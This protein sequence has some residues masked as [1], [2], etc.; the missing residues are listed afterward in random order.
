RAAA[1]RRR[2]TMA[3]TQC[4]SR[5]LRCDREYPTCS[6]CLKSRTPTKCTY[7]DGFLWQ[8]PATV[9]ATAFASDR[10]STVSLP[11]NEQT[12]IQTSPNPGLGP[13]STRSETL[14]STGDPGP[15]SNPY[16]GPHHHHHGRGRGH[17]G[18]ER[19]FLETVLGAPKAAVNQEP[20]VNAGF[21]Q[22]PK[23]A[24]P[25]L[26]IPFGSQVDGKGINDE[27]S[28]SELS[29]TQQLD[30][31]PRIMMR[32][33]ETKTRFSGSGIYAN[34]IAQFPDIRSFAEEIRLSNPILS[35]VR[36]DLE[37]VKRGLWKVKPLNTPFPEPT[38][39]SLISLLP[40]RQVVDEL[41]GLYLTYI[42]STHR[43]F[44]I[45]TFL[46]EVDD[47]FSMV[48]DPNMVSTA[49]VV[50]LLLVI[51]CAWN[52]ADA[53]S[54]QE[55]S[56]VPLKCYTAVEW[57]LHAERWIENARIKRFEIS[58]LRLYILLVTALN[59]H[60]MKR[61]KAWVTTGSLVQNAMLSGY[62]RD[63]SKYAR[64][65]PFNKEMRRRIWT[66]IV[67][68]NLQVSFDR[69]MP[70]SVQ[71]SDFDTLPPLNIDDE[72]IDET[73]TEAPEARPLTDIT[74]CSF[75]VALTRSLPLR[76]KACQLMHS[77]HI[78]CRYEEIQRLDLELNRQ[79]SRIPIWGAS[80]ASDI[81][82]QHKVSLRK[83]TIE[84]KIAQALL[85]IHT[86]F[87]I[88]AR[89]E[90]L[91]AP[92][93]R[94]RLD[95][96]IMILSTQRQLHTT[97]LPL[98]LCTLGEWVLQAYISICQHLHTMDHHNSLP[99]HPSSS[100]FTMHTLPGL[101]D[102]FLSLVEAGLISL[103][104]RFLLVVKGAKDYFFLSTIIALVKAKLWP[105][106]ELVYKQ[107]V[108]E[109]VLSFAQ[110]LFSR[111]A[112]CEHL[113]TPGMGSFKNNQ[114]AAFL[115]TRGMAAVL[116]SDFDGILLQPD[117]AITVRLLPFRRTVNPRAFLT[118][119]QPP[120]EFDPFLD[121]FDWEDL[122]GIAFGN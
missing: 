3:C 30:L 13:T 97:S 102:P 89:R 45:P 41:I 98:S 53:S 86:P 50:Q 5:K 95:A 76:L 91:F 34:L 70:P 69:A 73:S 71:S 43:I 84:L 103:E 88:E 67:E 99:S 113:G 20:Y 52:L 33:R 26:E 61:S 48:D 119:L 63:P 66:T 46:K 85:S 17:H 39:L 110:T 93:A 79:L 31:S 32:G 38:A 6:R 18:R 51:S 64:I 94:S 44:H 114:V 96:A 29:P 28:E 47:F 62:H 2:R 24:L 109:R 122:T 58:A 72:E 116:P 105:A 82:S 11:Q 80:D 83:A 12:P 16:E 9:P 65:S 107:Q 56:S 108:V 59:A 115:A 55:K 75:Q 27:D 4:R 8:Q 68:L 40:P 14:L 81:V 15:A 104:S 112:T 117:L 25:E 106:Q 100:I 111:H 118:M 78:S 60:G 1:Q 54:L 87:A 57:V 22:R 120:G 101:P 7:E 90:A 49:F 19:G 121:V 42:E 23:R 37:R 77:P 36:P 21:L 92:S 35:R 74:D 10:G